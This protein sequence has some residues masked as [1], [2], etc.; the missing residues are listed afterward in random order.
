[1]AHT[2]TDI[3]RAIEVLGRHERGRNAMRDLLAMLDN[4][5]LGLD[6]SG[7]HS[8]MLLLAAAF[9]SLPG[10]ACD[11]MRAAASPDMGECPECGHSLEVIKFA[12]EAEGKVT[13]P[14]C[15]WRK[16]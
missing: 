6:G 11:G 8:I 2:H 7:R 1:M 16:K 15:G 13:C 14:D 9:G 3:Q 5:G 10:S 4:G 12:N